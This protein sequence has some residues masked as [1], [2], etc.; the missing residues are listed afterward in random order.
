MQIRKNSPH[1][2][3]SEQFSVFSF[4]QKPEKLLNS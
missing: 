4:L 3:S 2:F 1:F